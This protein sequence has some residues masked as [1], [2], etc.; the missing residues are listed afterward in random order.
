MKFTILH[1]FK[2]IQIYDENSIFRTAKPPSAGKPREAPGTAKRPAAG[3]PR[4]APRTAKSPAAGSIS[5]FI[6]DYPS[7]Y[8]FVY[9]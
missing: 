7:T 2:S 9:L 4:K 6:I 3:A 8:Y 1:T 5:T